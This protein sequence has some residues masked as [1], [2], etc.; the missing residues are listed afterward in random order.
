[1]TMLEL[2]TKK[3]FEDFLKMQDH[4]FKL[5]ELKTMELAL[6]EK[7]R[8]PFGEICEFDVEESPFK[9]GC[10]F[11]EFETDNGCDR[12]LDQYNLPF[13][14]LYDSEYPVKYKEVYEKEQQ[15]LKVVAEFREEQKIKEERLGR[16]LYERS[17]Y[18]RLRKIYDPFGW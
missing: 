13:E 1:M 4:I 17:E 6:I 7:G 12:C 5:V 16:E 10:I 8:S 9:S 18:E 14:F 3:E 2:I 11:V 15:R